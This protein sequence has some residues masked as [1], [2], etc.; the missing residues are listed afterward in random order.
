MTVKMIDSVLVTEHEMEIKELLLESYSI[1]FNLSLTN[2]DKIVKDK[3]NDLKLYLENNNA[4]LFGKYITN[5]LVG[6]VWCFEYEYLYE[7]RMHINQIVVNSDYRGK[8]ISKELLKTVEDFTRGN[9]IDVIDLYVSN[10][11][12]I[13]ENLYEKNGFKINR[14]YLTKE[15]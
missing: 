8:G 9:N 12:K 11:N 4:F 10:S 7:K 13:A 6:F 3:M 14:K 15:L 5:K 1:N 2:L